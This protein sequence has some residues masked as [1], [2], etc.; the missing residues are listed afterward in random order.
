MRNNCGSNSTTVINHDRYE[1]DIINKY[2]NTQKPTG[3]FNNKQND[4]NYN[5]SML[6]KI[7]FEKQIIT[8]THSITTI[9]AIPTMTITSIRT[10]RC[11]CAHTH[12][13]THAT[14]TI[15]GLQRPHLP[16]TIANFQ[17]RTF[18]TTQK[19]LDWDKHWSIQNGSKREF[20]KFRSPNIVP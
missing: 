10:H 12:T 14:P 3:N 5:L 15:I 16:G 2:C 1:G 9:I 19:S 8:A 18:H 17:N 6:P 11:T 20:P 13:K 7:H 4:S